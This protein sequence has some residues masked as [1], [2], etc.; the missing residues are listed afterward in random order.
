MLLES[1]FLH[2]DCYNVK[3][4]EVPVENFV[5]PKVISDSIFLTKNDERYAVLSIRMNFW[6]CSFNCNH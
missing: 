4:V 6:N 3:T 5:L 2:Y 1:C